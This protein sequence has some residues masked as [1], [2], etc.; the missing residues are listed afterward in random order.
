MPFDPYPVHDFIDVSDVVDGLVFLS[1]QEA[2]GIYEFGTGIARSN[3]QVRKLVEK[4]TGKK[5]SAREKT[6]LRSYDNQDWHCSER[7]FKPLKNLEQ[8]ITEMVEAYK[9]EKETI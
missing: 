9:R 8:S 6:G 7:F 2:Q 1:E 5:A 3:N 4:I